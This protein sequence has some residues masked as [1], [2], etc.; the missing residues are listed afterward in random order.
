MK[1]SRLR[2]KNRTTMNNRSSTACEI[3][4]VRDDNWAGIGGRV[5]KIIGASCGVLMLSACGGGGGGGVA[6]TPPPPVVTPT[7]T[8]TPAPAPTNSVITDL[9]ANQSFANDG[10]KTDV[11]FNKVS[12]TTIVSRAASLPLTVSYDASSNSYTV[13][14]GGFSESFAPADKQA[15]QSSGQTSYVRRSGSDSSYLTLVT[16]PF[17]SQTT[18]KYVGL[19]YLQRN[20]STAERQDTGFVAFTYGLDTPASGVPRAGTGTFATDVF[21]LSSVP[22][23]EPEVFQGTGR[24]DVDF[25]NGLFS[26]ATSV[27]KRGLISGNGQVGG[28]IDLTGG[29]RLS[30]SNGTFSGDIVYSAGGPQIG[31]LLAGRFYGPNADEI[32]ASFSGS[33]SDGSAFTGALTGQRDTSMAATN[34]SFARMVTQQLFYADA[35][36]LTVRT[37]RSNGVVSVSDYPSSLGYGV[38][39][40]TL[41]DKTSGN[42]AFGTPSSNLAS[43]DYTVTSIVNGDPNFT[44]YARTIVDQPTRLEL[45]KT[46]SDNKELA[47]TY[48]SFGRYSTSIGT[49]PFS[50]EIDRVFFVYGFTT[51]S[52]LFANRTGSA[53]YSGVAYGAGADATGT[54]YDVTG[55][56]KMTVDFGSQSLSGNL[57]LIGRNGANAV[58]YGAFGFAGKL[59]SYSSSGT[60]DIKRNDTAIGSLLV[61]FYGPSADEAAGVFRLRVPD[62]VGANTLING[63]MV[64]KQQ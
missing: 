23:S 17:Y 9:R 22:G 12:S 34:I 42:V 30:S 52:G 14:G 59:F 6:S 16:T 35:T 2:T 24:F 49:D 13:A 40:G 36:T 1:V 32:G 46:G 15:S 44:S 38:S 7:P 28:G 61:N 43:G 5:K 8:P 3:C 45:Y 50:T 51:P 31:G 33:A 27:T 53:S 64:A 62:G 4:L 37:V 11:S 26:T 10:A 18:N 60:A 54:L 39:R 21:G 55:S 47:L 19:G 25:I 48:A 29:G 56:T 58:D 57:A 63:A 41:N 20:T